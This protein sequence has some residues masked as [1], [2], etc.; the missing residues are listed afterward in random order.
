MGVYL[1]GFTEKPGINTK[2]ALNMFKAIPEIEAAQ[3]N[4]VVEQRS[5]SISK[6]VVS[7]TPND[8]YYDDQWALRNTGQF[9]GTYGVDIRAESAWSITESNLTV[10]GDEIVIAVIDSRFE[11]AH[12]DLNFWKN[13]GETPSNGIDDDG[14]GYI[15]DY[16]GWNAYDSNGNLSLV[17]GFHGT[18]VTGIAAAKGRNNKGIAGVAFN[19]KVLPIMGSTSTES[20]VIEAYEYVLT[21]RKQYNV[22]NGLEGAFITVTN[23]S[24][25]RSGDPV[26]FPGWCAA[27]DSLGTYGV[28]NVVAVANSTHDV[29]V[30]GGIPES[31]DSN[32]LITVTNTDHDD[33]LASYAAY[34]DINVDLGAPGENILSSVPALWGAT[35]YNNKYARGLTGSG[36]SQATPHVTGTVALMFANMDS[37]QY[38]DY[39][40]NPGEMVQQIKT[41]V[42]DSVDPVASLNGK[43]VSNG[44][45]N[46][47]NAL[48][49]MHYEDPPPTAP[50]NL[51]LNSGPSFPSLSWD[52]VTEANS[53]EIYRR[54]DFGYYVDCTPKL[55]IIGTSGSNSYTDWTVIQNVNPP[56]PEENYQ[57]SVIAVNEVG[58]SRYSNRVDV[59]GQ[60][61]SQKRV[62]QNKDGLPLEIS[63]TQ[64]YPN[65]F[66]PQT[67]IEY[68]LPVQN[69]INIEVFDIL[70]RSVGILVNNEDKAAGKHSTVFNAT[71]LS[72]GLYIAK[73]KINES[74]IQTIKM[75][76]V[77]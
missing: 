24:F 4:H 63:V 12:E 52:A 68:Q 66:N 17:D 37:S 64:N 61:S 8:E 59:Y 15:D 72:S 50:E 58:N 32:Y 22:T 18:H 55:S 40:D 3:L 69:I 13:T 53:Y 75:Q 49:A 11:L 19:T 60:S 54:C 2:A 67:T 29:D 45:L 70:G 38:S 73:F 42:L 71:H 57:Y 31:C 34:G 43:T 26:D 65:P 33:N 9:G 76:L 62:S 44:R 7:S 16:D 35:A 14:N 48:L 25:G 56:N 6:S 21:L 27:Y 41:W 74:Y 46:A 30:V 20:V 10:N 28:V 39:E 23:S 51:V 1:I 5:K 77:K 36:T 47:Y